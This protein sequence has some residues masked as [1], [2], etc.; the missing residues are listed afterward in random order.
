L[1][2][3]DWLIKEFQWHVARHDKNM[4]YQSKVLREQALAFIGAF[5]SIEALAL[6]TAHAMQ[7]EQKTTRR[8][9]S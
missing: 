9:G 7:Q 1:D 2:R 4:D 8:S 3:K 5:T 6:T